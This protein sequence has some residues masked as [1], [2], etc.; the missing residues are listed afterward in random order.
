MAT[1]T[2]KEVSEMTGISNYTLRFYEKEGV[3]PSVKRDES[4]KRAYDEENIEWLHFVVALRSTGMPLSEIKQYVNWYKEGDSS[5]PKRKQMMIDHKAKIEQKMREL[6][7]YLEQINYKLA[8]YD[9]Q[10]KTLNQ[11][12]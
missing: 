3:L 4:G 2:I 12:P 7:K 1:Y 10:E 9:V 5:L 8:L 11:L 6:Y